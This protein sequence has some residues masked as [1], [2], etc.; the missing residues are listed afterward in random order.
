MTQDKAIEILKSDR[1]V[2]LT[3]QPGTGKTYTTN[4]FTDWL[5]DNGDIP[6]ITASTG[7]AA[8]HV[9][10]QTLHAWAGIRGDDSLSDEDMN[11]ILSNDYTRN[12]ICRTHTLIIDEISMISD[13]LLN[14]V[15]KL[16]MVAK[17]NA[18]PFGGIKLIV[19]G[20]FYQLPPVK[21]GYAF[22][23][24]AWE[25]ADFAV[26]YLHEQHRQSDK[27][28]TDILTGIRSGV[29]DET[30][31]Q[32]LRDRRIT[33]AHGIDAIRLDTHNVAV[34][35]INDRKLSAVESAP[36]TYVMETKGNVMAVKGLVKNCL[37]PERL[38]LKVGVP[39]L[40]TKNDMDKR[41]VNGSQGTV[42]SLHDNTV[43]VELKSGET[44]E[45]H[46]QVWE[47]AEGYGSNKKVIASVKQLPLK[48]AYA[49]TIHKSQGMTLDAAIIDVSKVFACGHAYVATSRVKSLEGLHY[50]NELTEGFLAVDPKVQAMD[51][52]FL[53]AS[54]TLD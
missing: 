22:E 48:L 18:R 5:L 16:C 20:D 50:Q 27:V 43:K 44:V 26:C 11:Q 24:S 37:S 21:G 13:K 34:D 41:F 42:V 6:A 17:G 47:R 14:V 32:I 51:K 19:V 3:G 40:C 9:G 39:V 1:N 10:G 25:Q 49:I 33:D 35:T 31:K 36:K 23:S 29:L 12:R 15:S 53:A 7:I 8:V 38:T 30:Q 52:V 4:S 46:A 54:K 45:I 2:F 28:F